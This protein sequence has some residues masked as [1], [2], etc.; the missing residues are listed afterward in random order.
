MTT[1][2]V[3]TSHKFWD[4]IAEG[5]AKRPVADEASYQYKLQTTQGYLRPDMEV[6]EIGCGT[7]STALVHAPHV[8]HV[9]AVDIS[10]NMI[11][12]ARDKA[13]AQGVDNATF[14]RASID[15]LEVEPA[16]VDVVLALSLLHLLRDRESAIARIYEW[17]RPGGL[18]VTSTACL[19]G[20]WKMA[21]MRL[22]LPI[23]RLFGRLPLVRF[24]TGDELEA[25]L[26]AAGFETEHRWTPGKGKAVFMVS[27]K[28]GNSS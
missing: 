25:S 7:G 26:S 1:S 19:G 4:R 21:P 14:E 8:K 10:A 15:E 6:L 2:T 13:A 16:S 11:D 9:R 24:F 28:P 3:D 22:V 12:I 18:L 5:Y 20:Q 23:G 27:R 17:L